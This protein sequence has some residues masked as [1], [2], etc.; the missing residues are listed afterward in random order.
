MRRRTVA[1][2]IHVDGDLT[3]MEMITPTFSRFRGCCPKTALFSLFWLKKALNNN[4]H[5]PQTPPIYSDSNLEGGGALCFFG[6]FWGFLDDF[7]PVFGSWAS[8]LQFG[9]ILRG[10][11]FLALIFLGF[12]GFLIFSCFLFFWT[13][14]SFFKLKFSYLRI[15]SYLV[16]KNG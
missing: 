16:V 15:V 6:V 3:S 5:N 12:F 1:N 8:R 13:F 4:K 7:G 14:L 2:F 11:D 9:M 10:L